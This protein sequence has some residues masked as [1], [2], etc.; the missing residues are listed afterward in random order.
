MPPVDYKN[1]AIEVEADGDE[2]VVKAPSLEVT[3][4]FSPTMA[5]NL[6][7]ALLEAATRA[8]ENARV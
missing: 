3:M 6:A 1:V 2:V 8:E 7:A 5:T 4:K